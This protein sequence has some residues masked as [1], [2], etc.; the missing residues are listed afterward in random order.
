MLVGGGLGALVGTGIG[1]MLDRWAGPKPDAP[2]DAKAALAPNA[3][4]PPPSTVRTGSPAPSKLSLAK[5]TK[6]APHEVFG[7]STFYLTTS[8]ELFVP[9]TQFEL[10]LQFKEEREAF[11]EA[12]AAIDDI[13]GFESLLLTK[14]P[15]SNIQLPILAQVARNRVRQ[16]LQNI[17][18][19]SNEQRPSPTKKKS[20]EGYVQTV[21][22]NLDGVLTHMHRQHAATTVYD[23]AKS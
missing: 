20:M 11:S 8:N 2:K 9:L 14:N 3:E 10:L 17:V 12:I 16:L 18:D 4:N 13:F 1:Y 15:L 5:P 22:Q 23:E 7:V 6:P 21:L 19:F